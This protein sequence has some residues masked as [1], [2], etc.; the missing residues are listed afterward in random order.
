MTMNKSSQSGAVLSLPVVGTDYQKN[1]AVQVNHWKVNSPFKADWDEFI[2]D[3]EGHAGVEVRR[4]H[5]AKCLK[6]TRHNDAGVGRRSAVSD[7][8]PFYSKDIAD[9]AKCHL[10][11]SH[12]QKA[13]KLGSLN[14]MISQGYRYI[15][16]H[17]ARKCKGLSALSARVLEDIL[18]DLANE[19]EMA[20][21]SIYRVGVQLQA[22]S[23]YI[24]KFG[25]SKRKLH[26]KNPIKRSETRTASDFSVNAE[27]DLLKHEN[28]LSKEVLC[29]VGQLGLL[30]LSE[31]DRLLHSSTVVLFCTGL[32]IDE[33]VGLQKGSLRQVTEEEACHLTGKVL[34]IKVWKLKVKSRKGGGYREVYIDDYLAPIAKRAFDYIDN[35]FAPI[36]ETARQIEDGEYDFSTEEERGFATEYYKKLWANLESETTAG[37]LSD[38]LFLSVKNHF[39]SQ[40]RSIN[41]QFCLLTETLYR[42]FISGRKS[43]GILSV[44]ERYGVTL[45]GKSFHISSHKFRHFLNT[46][47]Q[48]H[49]HTTEI[50]IA[51]YFG[52][53]FTGDNEAYDHTNKAKW[54][55]DEACTMEEEDSG[56]VN[57]EQHR[58]FTSQAGASSDVDESD[59]TLETSAGRCSHL[60]I[61]S[62]CEKHYACLRFC[63]NYKRTKGK[64]SE[65]EEI[66]RIR[67]RAIKEIEIAKK[68]IHED[69]YGANN[70]LV[71]QQ[72]L[73]DGCDEA[74]A[75]EDNDS[76]QVGEVIWI[77]N[78]GH[79]GCGVAA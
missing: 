36:R 43:E 47:L 34:E 50:E 58:S 6:F 53:K 56:S 11:Y 41:W 5:M 72:E 66:K 25:L 9:I 27:E 24:D 18:S 45:D 26:F 22:A 37:K 33:L 14:N 51:T 48:L 8:R 77:F 74:L 28:L 60:F 62:P 79:K 32:R 2:W 20:P 38:M 19:S 78:E 55:F 44:F 57:T 70:W 52:R 3:V 42:D 29:A 71:K 61:E 63:Q 1:L 17:L 30:P 69:F 7:D 39:N 15:D 12:T 21:A 65:I 4:A 68:A 31:Q 23:K 64:Q 59:I 76:I 67:A 10:C 16:R 73:L 49:E 35:Y 40:R 13:K 75:I 54:A 46:M